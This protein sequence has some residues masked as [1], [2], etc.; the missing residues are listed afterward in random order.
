MES[1]FFPV[2]TVFKMAT[3]FP[4]SLSY[5][6][7]RRMPSACCQYSHRSPGYWR[8][9]R[10][11]V[12]VG[13]GGWANSIWILTL[14]DAKIFESGKK[15]FRIKKYTDMCG[16]GLRKLSRV[17]L[18]EFNWLIVT[19]HLYG[20]AERLLNVEVSFFLSKMVYYKR[21]TPFA[22]GWEAI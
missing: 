16:L 14:V 13:Y 3:S 19:A 5:P 7:L 21:L 11:G 9:I 22:N 15:T 12:G 6:S 17:Y 8:E 18:N 1:P 10:I 20:K 4:G 2:N